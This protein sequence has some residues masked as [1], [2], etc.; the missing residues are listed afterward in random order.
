MLNSAKCHIWCNMVKQEA[1]VREKES[2]MWYLPK[3]CYEYGHFQR[4]ELIKEENGCKQ[5][6]FWT[7][8]IHLPWRECI[9]G[10]Q[11]CEKVVGPKVISNVT[12]E[13]DPEI[14]LEAQQFSSYSKTHDK[15]SHKRNSIQ[16]FINGCTPVLD[17]KKLSL[18]H[19][20]ICCEE[21]CPEKKKG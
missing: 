14:S 10:T 4:Y 13:Y 11:Y 5:I 2:C 15:T 20:A 6:C 8:I 9:W 1:H 21:Y 3:V 19:H 16:L 7:H 12:K 17:G 18:N